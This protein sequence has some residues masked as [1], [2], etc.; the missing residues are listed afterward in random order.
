M[1]LT[2]RFHQLQN[3]A[4]RILE[5]FPSSSQLV[6]RRSSRIP[7]RATDSPC[8]QDCNFSRKAFSF[9]V[10]CIASL[11]QLKVQLGAEGFARDLY[12]ATKPLLL[13]SSKR[14]DT[15]DGAS[16][17]KERVV[18]ARTSFQTP[19]E[20]PNFQLAQLPQLEAAHTPSRERASEQSKTERAPP[21]RV[22]K[23]K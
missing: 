8:P 5:L 18:G 14:R 3:F 6:R 9:S 12:Q 17:R 11:A 10:R 21:V 13:R 22:A 16:C 23:L 7:T 1:S 19:G 4:T 15:H 2:I 20:R